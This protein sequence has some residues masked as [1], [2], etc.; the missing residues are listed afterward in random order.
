METRFISLAGKT[1]KPCVNC[2]Y[3]VRNKTLCKIKDDMAPLYE[4]VLWADGFIVGSPVYNMNITAQLQG[5]FN[6]WRPL[7]H[8]H[9]GVLHNRVG[10]AIAV[11]GSRN[12]GQELTASAIIHVLLSRGLVVTG[13]G[14]FDSYSGAYVVSHDRLAQGAK[15]D[16]TGM[17]SV[18]RLGR[19]VAELAT[20]IKAGRAE[21]RSEDR[22]EG[23]AGG[24]A[25]GPA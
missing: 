20:W 19:R 2:D 10:G 24:R 16:E 5:F 22:A 23:R 13:G 14:S 6:R 8:V 1:I 9:D 11:G 25:E 4:D 15:D 18:R 7:H 21:G 3:C 17:D 12:G